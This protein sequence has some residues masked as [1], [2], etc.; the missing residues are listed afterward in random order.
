MS[1]KNFKLQ[2]LYIFIAAIVISFSFM[3]KPSYAVSNRDNLRNE[4]NNQE[5]ILE[6]EMNPLD[7]LKSDVTKSIYE[8]AINDIVEANKTTTGELDIKSKSDMLQRFVFKLIVNTR[9]ISIYAYV[10]IWVL[11]ILYASTFGSRDVNKRRKVYL[12]LRNSTVLFLIYIN[13]PL[14]II[15][16]NSDKT[17]LSDIS[18]INSIY[19]GLEFLQ[20]NSLVISGLMAYAGVSRLIISRND[21]PVRKQGKYLTKFSVIM[22][23]CLNVAPIAMYFLI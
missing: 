11:G 8:K 13:I 18:I 12:I 19:A 2:R 17:K 7:P 14:V 6:E 5:K 20:R 4:L 9:T 10:G 15:W 21:L 16:L 23:I 1:K 22:F 3:I